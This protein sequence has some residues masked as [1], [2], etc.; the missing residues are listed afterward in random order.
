MLAKSA[1]IIV[2][3]KFNYYY[4]LF[5]YMFTE[6]FTELFKRDFSTQNPVLVGI[7]KKV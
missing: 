4:L 6:I 7:A 2:N 3:L 5:E 1:V